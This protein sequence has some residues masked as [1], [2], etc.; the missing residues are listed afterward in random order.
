MLSVTER[1][2]MIFKMIICMQIG[3]RTN[4]KGLQEHRHT[5]FYSASLQCALQILRFFFLQSE[6]LWPP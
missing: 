3:K 4:L 2:L 1:S 5:L 6:G